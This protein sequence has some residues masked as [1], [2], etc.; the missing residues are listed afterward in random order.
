MQ[1]F[2]DEK[3]GLKD[4]WEGGKAPTQKDIYN[5]WDEPTQPTVD[6]FNRQFGK[7]AAEAILRDGKTDPIPRDPED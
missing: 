1:Q 5:L 2:F 6:S 7:G 4:Q 3:G